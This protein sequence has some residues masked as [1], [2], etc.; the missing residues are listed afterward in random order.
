MKEDA[1]RPTI[2]Q[3]AEKAGVSIA[4]VSHVINKTRYV[5]PELMEKVINVI[6][7]TGYDKKIEDKTIKFKVGKL[8]EIAFV[9][10]NIGSSVYSKIAS[11]LSDNLKDM[12]YTLSTFLTHDDIQ[13]EKM[14]LRDLLAN[15]RIAGIILVPASEDAAN[16]RKIL[17][18]KLPLICLERAVRGPEID[19]I[20]SQNVQAIYS[21]TEHLIKRGHVNISLLLDHRKLSTVEDRL[22]GYRKALSD[23]GIPFRE[24]YVL[25]VDLYAESTGKQI[26]EYFGDEM[27]TAI[28]AGGN[29]LTFLLLRQLKKQGLECPQD[30]SIIGF[31]DDEWCELFTPPLTTLTQDTVELGRVATKKIIDKI[32]GVDDSP[33]KMEV[34]VGLTIRE[35]TQIISH[36]PFGEKAV[37]PELIFL[38][39]E[40]IER[41][42]NGNF[43][44]AISF[45]YSGDL[46]TKLHEQAIRDTLARYKVKV[47]SVA[48]AH[49]DPDLQI[50]QL[51]GLLMQR[52]DV[53]IAVPSDEVKTAK[54]FKE[55]SKETRLIMINNM[56]IDFEKEDYTAWIS[57]NECENGQN[58]GK[59]LR[60]YFKEKPMG[61]V[62]LL[63]HGIPFFATQQR[64]F[65]AEQVLQ[66][67]DCVQIVA[68]RDFIKIESTYNVCRE[69]VLDHPEIQGL[70]VTWERPALEAIRALK[71]LGREDIVIATTDLDMEIANY[72]SMGKMVIGLSSQRPY[73]QGVVVALATAKALLNKTEYK[74]IGV[75][76]YTVLR[77]N[78]SKAW[79]DIIKTPI[80]DHL[81]RNLN[82][83]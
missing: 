2:K 21:A 25:D 64:D 10:P 47:T 22:D 74:C 82:M 14:I 66:D 44:V 71:E 24:K 7:E 31:G 58:A 20:L 17:S 83:E 51:E 57:V 68:K 30:V 76:P 16:Y 50:T 45:H 80:P 33:K 49:L 59:I 73:E 40:E 61:K 5:S 3:I 19:C 53:I 78:L 77:K 63:T 39:D 62:G 67:S 81:A 52:P 35:S 32:N 8:S 1:M 12:G 6:E 42:V 79:N 54:K 28:I 55:I 27:P 72:L 65:A 60:D 36:G 43:K 56:P 9:V 23:Y 70:Y 69:L 13:T 41:L 18:A 26:Q 4:T 34:G 75:S 38:S 46:W 11:A 37:G 48:D 15:K 29:T